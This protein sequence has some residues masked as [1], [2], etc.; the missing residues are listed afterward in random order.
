MYLHTHL[1]QTCQFLQVISFLFIY[2]FLISSVFH[3]IQELI[4]FTAVK[5]P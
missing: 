4:G 3:P 1:L 5:R 2:L